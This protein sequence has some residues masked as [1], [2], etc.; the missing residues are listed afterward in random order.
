MNNIR[1]S[2]DDYDKIEPDS[3]DLRIFSEEF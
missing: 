3:Y 2:I 1:E